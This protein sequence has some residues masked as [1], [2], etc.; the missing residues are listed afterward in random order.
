M[1]LRKM[2]STVALAGA[3]AAGALIAAP[4]AQAFSYTYI[5]MFPDAASCQAAGQGY[6]NRG[7][8]VNYFCDVAPGAAR[9]S[10]VLR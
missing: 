10:V 1:A 3:L 8:A 4:A 7:E 2:A 6:V 5:G 9:L